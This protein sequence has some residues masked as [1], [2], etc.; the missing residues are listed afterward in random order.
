[1]ALNNIKNDKWWWQSPTLPVKATK[2]DLIKFTIDN[3]VW[4]NRLLLR[5]LIASWTTFVGVLVG[6]NVDMPF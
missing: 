5:I 6:M 2:A 3:L 4:Q 1:M